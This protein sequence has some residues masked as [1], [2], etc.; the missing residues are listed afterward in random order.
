MDDCN[1]YLITRN[2]QIGGV[3][4]PLW[5]IV[6]KPDSALLSTLMSVQIPL[7]TIVTQPKNLLHQI[8]ARSD[9]SMDDC[10][11]GLLLYLQGASQVQIPL[12]TIVT[13][14]NDAFEYKEA[15]SDS[16]MDDCNVN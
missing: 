16:S 14:V 3:Q 7:W 12:W 15:G 1:Q 6:T 9:S 8:F 10:N 2:R 11:Q 4:I 13:Y 5:T